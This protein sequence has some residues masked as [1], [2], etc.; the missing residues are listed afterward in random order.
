MDLKFDSIEVIMQVVGDSPFQSQKFKLM[1]GII[2]LCWGEASA[3]KSDWVQTLS[4]VLIEDTS[5]TFS[6]CINM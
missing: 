5:Q 2:F 6:A 1:C 4:L 3:D